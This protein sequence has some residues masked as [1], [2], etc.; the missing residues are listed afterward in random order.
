MRRQVTRW[1]NP[2]SQQGGEGGG[3]GS[4][5][6]RNNKMKSGKRERRGSAGGKLA[7][8]AEAAFSSPPG[9]KAEGGKLH[10]TER[11]G[12]CTSMISEIFYPFSL[13]THPSIMSGT[14][15][16]HGHFLPLSN[17]LCKCSLVVGEILEE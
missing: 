12:S 14:C 7:S 9:V 2:I 15:S 8:R 13:Q 11:E 4:A 10:P 6:K 17:V 3:E 1:G 16:K 5:R